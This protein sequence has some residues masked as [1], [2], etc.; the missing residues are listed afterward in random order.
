MKSKLE[1]LLTLLYSKVAGK[2]LTEMKGFDGTSFVNGGSFIAIVEYR[3]VF[4]FFFGGVWGF[5]IL[6]KVAQPPNKS[7]ALLSSAPAQISI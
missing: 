1:S 2:F 6:G 4:G 3:R 7:Q 5:R